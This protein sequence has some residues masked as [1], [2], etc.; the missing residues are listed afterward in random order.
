MTVRSSEG[1]FDCERFVDAVLDN[2]N[3]SVQAKEGSNVDCTSGAGAMRGLGLVTVGI[4]A[5]VSLVGFL[6]YSR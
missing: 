4:A 1:G 2:T 6:Q 5:M 3:A